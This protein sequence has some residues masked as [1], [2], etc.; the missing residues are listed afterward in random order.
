MNAP[1]RPLWMALP[2]TWEQKLDACL[3]QAAPYEAAIFFR[4]D[5]AAAVGK[6]FLKMLEMFERRATFLDIA[7]VPAWLTETR[8]EALLKDAAPPLFGLHQHGFR[9]VNHE[10]KGKKCEFGPGRPAAEKQRDVLRGKQRLEELL[11]E[12]FQPIFSPPWNRV[13]ADTLEILLNGRFGAL[14]RFRGAKP[15]APA[16]LASL[17]ANV[18]M[19]TRKEPDP[20][21]ALDDLLGELLLALREGLAGIMLHHQV[22]NDAAFAFLDRLLQGLASLPSVAAAPMAKLAP[23]PNKPI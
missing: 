17:D 18:D 3:E 5:D 4:D 8:A 19:H 23:F 14:S 21:K 7:V 1:V 10:T 12:R 22:M 11:G 9:H 6:N 20:E 16:G 15:A 13:D 2:R